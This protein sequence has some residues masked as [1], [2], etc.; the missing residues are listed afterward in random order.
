MCVS[1]RACMCV[2]GMT[3]L[4][5]AEGETHARGK[6]GGTGAKSGVNQRTLRHPGNSEWLSDWVCVCACM[7][8]RARMCVCACVWWTY[9]FTNS[10][11]D[12]QEG[13]EY[14]QPCLCW[15]HQ[16]TSKSEWGPT[17]SE[18]PRNWWV[19]VC[20]CVCVCVWVWVCGWVWVCVCVC[21]CGC[22]RASVCGCVTH[23]VNGLMI[24]LTAGGETRRRGKSALSSVSDSV[25]S[26]QRGGTGAKSGGNRQTLRHPQNGECVCVC[27]RACVHACVWMDWW[28]Y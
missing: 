13:Q 2:N 24:L 1:V 28:F 26:R 19:G 27:V 17:N 4:L 25:S 5:T 6:S 22:A 18:G 8:V 15:Q 23:G 21:V 14:C 10:W 16:L 3:I 11:R 9:D 20:V 12:S 7:C